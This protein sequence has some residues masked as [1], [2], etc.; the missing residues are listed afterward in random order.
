MRRGEYSR[1]KLRYTASS[2]RGRGGVWSGEERGKMVHTV[3]QG[4]YSSL[5]SCERVW[6]EYKRLSANAAMAVMAT[7][8]HMYDWKRCAR[9]NCATCAASTASGPLGW[10][11]GGGEDD[12]DDDD[13]EGEGPPSPPATGA[14]RWCR[15][16]ARALSTSFS[17]V[18]SLIH[19]FAFFFSFPS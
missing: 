2:G 11:R 4:L 3:S 19:A 17:L 5:D 6:N 16:A 13:D 10:L 1:A 18:S 12:D 7:P 9:R 14:W 8:P 15:S